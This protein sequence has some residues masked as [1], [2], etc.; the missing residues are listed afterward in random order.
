[1]YLLAAIGVLIPIG[2]FIA[3]STRIG[4]S[5][6]ERRFAAL[7]LVGATPQ[8]VAF[9]AALEAAL[10]GV[11]GAVLGVV[12]ALALRTRA[13]D[14]GIAGYS[15]FPADLSPPLWQV[16]LIVVAT[17][18]LAAAAALG[19]MRRV[20]VTPLGVRRRQAPGA[21]SARRLIPLVAVVG[22]AGRGRPDRR[23]PG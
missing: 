3:A 2:V 15:A 8:Q 17:P 19:S 10:A 5:T 11:F 16:G 4:A 1:M 20:V 12:L 7:R 14:L 23:R 21:P 18:L 6:R 9:A 13:A 22:R